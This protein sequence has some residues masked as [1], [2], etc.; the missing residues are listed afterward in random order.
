MKKTIKL[1]LPLACASLLL[2]AVDVSAQKINIDS[3]TK[4]VFKKVDSI[5]KNKIEDLERF[6]Q[7][8]IDKISIDGAIRNLYE[9]KLIN[10]YKYKS[11]RR[12]RKC[13]CA[14]Q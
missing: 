13:V 11:F 7:H 12:F 2:C 3:L 5:Y 10:C 1:L 6:D 9:M 14:V 8:V 4:V